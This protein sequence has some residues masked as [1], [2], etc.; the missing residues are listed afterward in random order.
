M[1]VS[2]EYVII[3]RLKKIYKAN[4]IAPY[5]SFVGGTQAPILDT[6]YH[7]RSPLMAPVITSSAILFENDLLGGWS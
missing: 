7:G 5:I 1:E 6:T 3:V 2:H 4:T